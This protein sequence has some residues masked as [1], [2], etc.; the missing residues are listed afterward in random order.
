MFYNDV[1]ADIL[2]IKAK[3]VK[4]IKEN[5]K[6]KQNLRFLIT[7]AI[8]ESNLNPNAIGRLKEKGLYQL[9]PDFFNLQNS[10]IKEQTQVAEKHLEYLRNNCTVHLSLCWNL[11]VSKARSLKY[12]KKFKYYLKFKEVYLNVAKEM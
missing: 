5:V 1:S 7:T 3:T 6:N 10:S 4:A 2:N 8:I 9:H 12:P 11:G